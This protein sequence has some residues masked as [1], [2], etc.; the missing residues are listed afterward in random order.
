MNSTGYSTTAQSSTGAGGTTAIAQPDHGYWSLEKCKK[1]YLDYLNNKQDEINE[2]KDARRYYHGAQWTEEQ[3]KV[4]NLRRQPV[5]TFNRVQRKIDGI[6]GLLER[7]RQEPKAYPRTPEHE[8]GA[9]LSTAALRYVLD[10]QEWKAKAPECARDGAI[11]GIAGIEIELEEGDNGDNDVG[12]EIVE[13][14]S[15]FYDPRSYRMDFTDARYMGVGKWVDTDLAKEMF[16]DKADEID[17]ST[18]NA[19]D[20]TTNPDRENKWFSTVGGRTMIRLIDIWYQHKGGWCWAL[21]TGSSKL[22]EG[23]SYFYDEKRKTFCKF[24]MFSAGVDHDGDRYGFVRHMRSA[25]DEINSRRSRAMF[26]LQSRRLLLT[27]G[28]VEDV[29][30]ARREWARPDGL[31]E[32]NASNVNEGVKADDQSFD[33]AGQL[34]MLENATQELENYGPNQ[35]LIG[36]GSVENSSGRAIALL[37]QAGIAELGPYILS[38][39]AWK[40]RV[41]RAL[42]N[43]IQQHWT[44]ERWIR[45]TDDEGLAQFIQVNGI[46]VDPRTGLPTLVNALGSLDVDIILDEGPDSINAMA[47]VYDTLKETLPTIAPMLKPPEASAALKVLIDSSALPA[48]AK[49]TFRDASRQAQQP[50]PMAQQ[51]Q[52]VEM[53]GA[54]A[55][56][57]ETQSKAVLNL[58]NAGAAQTPDAPQMGQPQPA[59]LPMDIQVDQANAEIMERLAGARLKDAQARKADTESMLAPAKAEH[60][61]SLAEANFE[62]GIKDRDADRKMAARTSNGS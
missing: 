9:E 62:Q 49:K 53:A 16:P 18:E 61:A 21:F 34:K 14:D 44:A 41:Y 26:T 28:S 47:D 42:W 4:F 15:F 31:V 43:A 33:F 60:D 17:A 57:K 29:E 25:Q 1:A 27:K 20:L 35:A 56:V 12:F 48:S 40:V 52:Q 22:M 30:V 2:Q 13:P 38:F 58:A 5:V 10:E 50:D 55:K 39:R 36:A 3:I 37:Q 24:L 45:V 8:Q 7:M 32:V 19:T 46:Q 59:E 6:I 11:D 54:I 23:R 51:A